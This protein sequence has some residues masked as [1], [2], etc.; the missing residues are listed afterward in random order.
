MKP[1]YR[2][3]PSPTAQQLQDEALRVFGTCGNLLVSKRIRVTLLSAAGSTKI[4]HGLGAVP[5]DVMIGPPSSAAIVYRQQDPDAKFLYLT[6]TL[7]TTVTV[8][9]L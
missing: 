8:W 6:T 3:I 1:E 2:A 9:L 7:N 4:A 5:E